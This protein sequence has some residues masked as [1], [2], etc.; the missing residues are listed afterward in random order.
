MKVTKVDIKN[1]IVD[2]YWYCKY[3][4]GIYH[5]LINTT[6]K[7]VYYHR[8]CNYEYAIEEDE[9]GE[10]GYVLNIDELEDIIPQ[11]CLCTTFQEKDQISFYWIPLKMIS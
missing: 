9:N 11:G 10:D 2:S 6:H 7:W 8:Y 3:K 1:G 5:L 4:S